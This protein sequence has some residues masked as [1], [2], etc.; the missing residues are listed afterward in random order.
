MGPNNLEILIRLS[1]AYLNKFITEYR[2]ISRD[3][4]VR[5][6]TKREIF[7]YYAFL[8]TKDKR[9][10]WV[11]SG[12]ELEEPANKV[13]L[14]SLIS[15]EED[16]K[17]RGSIQCEEP[18]F[19]SELF[20]DALE[21]RRTGKHNM[22]ILLS[23]TRFENFVY[24]E[25]TQVLSKRKLDRI[26][27]KETCGCMEGISQVCTRGFKEVFDFD[28]EATEEWRN[29]RDKAIRIRNKI[30]H[31][32]QLAEVTKDACKEALDAVAIAE[33]YIHNNLFRNLEGY[34]YPKVR[35]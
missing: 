4:W 3:H 14:R 18:F 31:G 2:H 22:A 15:D 35:S 29:I 5:Q 33:T 25:L 8:A 21:Y 30:V 20:L 16:L 28:F 13:D 6:I 10:E 34:V 11:F 23:V 17:L 24:S 9:T 19:R 12:I 7:S 1:V 27:K 26:K 32:E